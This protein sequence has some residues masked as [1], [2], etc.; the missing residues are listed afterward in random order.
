MASNTRTL[1]DE[2]GDF[3]DWIELQNTSATN[4]NL[5]NWALTDS[6]G[7]P[8]EWL[9]P[10]TNIGPGNFLIVFASGKDRRVAGAPLHTSFK[11]SAD[12]E[13]LALFR[14]D[15]TAATEFSPGFPSQ[16]PDVSYGVGMCTTNAYWRYF[17]VPTPGLTNGTSTNDLG[18]L[19]S[20]AG[21]GPLVPR[22]S[23]ALVVTA[24]VAQA[25]SPVA[26]VALHYRVMFS[27]EVTVAM[28][29][30][31][32]N[33]DAL[34]GDGIWSGTIPGSVAG[35]G[36]MIRYYVTAVDAAQNSSRWPIYANAQESQQYFGTVVRDDSIQS[37]LPVA[38]F[39][40]ENTAASDT[41]TGTPGS[42]F[43]LGEFYDNLTVAIHGQSSTG[44]PKKSHDLDFPKD[45]QFLYRTNGVREKKITF[46]S[47]YGDKARLCTSLTYAIVAQ[48]GG[49]AFFSF[50]IRIHL[51][52]SFWGIEDLVEH[53][54]EA[55]LT[56]IGRDPNGALYKMY[57]ALDS[58]SGN[59]K[60]TRE[61]EGMDDL[62]ALITSLDEARPQADRETFAYDNLDLPQTANYFATLAIA[63]EQDHGHKNYFLYH[64]NDGTG[65][66]AI[67]PWDVDLSWGR[68]WLDYAGYFTDTIF[69]NNVL[70]FYNPAQ[71]YKPN[72]RLYDLFFASTEFRQMY[73]RRLR[74]LMD[75]V[76]LPP[77]TPV[78]TTT[79][80]QFILTH[81]SLLNPPGISPTDAQLDHA[82]WGPAWGDWGLGQDPAM[83]ELIRTNY[84]P[85]RRGFLFQSAAATL[86]GD[87]IPAA[88]PTNATVLI[89]GWDYAPVSGNANEQ[90]VELHNTNAFAADV[91]GWKLGG[92]IT[93]TLRPGTVI[94]AGKSLYVAANVN[95][96]RT[97][98]VSPH[99]GQ[100]IF[101]QGPFSGFLSSQGNSALVL[102]DSR[103]ALVSQNVYAINL[104]SNAFAAGNLA[105]VRVGNGTESLSSHGNSVFI[106]QF[107]TNGA[108]IGSVAVPN[109]GTNGF[110]I[111]G[112]ASSEGGL[113]RSPDGRLLVLAGYRI[114]LTNAALLSSS[115]ANGSSTNAPRGLMA[116]DVTG[117]CGLVGVVT[118]QFSGNN[119]RGGA[120][121]GRGNYWGAGAVS[122]TYY[123]GDGAGATVQ[124]VV[125][126]TANIE[127]AGGNLY[128]STS[129][130][131]PGIWKIC[132]TP[133]TA[134]NATVVLTSATASPFAFA[135]NPGFTT[136]Y[137]AD[138]TPGSPGGVQRWDLHGNAWTM[139]YAFNGLTS[140][141]ARGLAVDFGTVPPVIYATTAE[142]SA[143]RLVALADTGAAA[144]VNT[145]ATSGVNQLYRG[146]TFT[147]D[148]GLSP[149]MFSAG[150]C[151]NGFRLA[152]T[153]LMNRCYTVEYAD[154]LMSTNWVTLTNV[155]ACGPV[156]AV[157]DTNPAIGTNRF[158]RIG[159]VGW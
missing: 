154:D 83:A 42:L 43:Y 102:K 41:E 110:I 116:V 37:L 126:N 64:D 111:S 28:N 49:A 74:T 96:F 22:A 149:Q 70:N 136:A 146:V 95:A 8:A 56:R 44:W 27:S 36:Q 13:Y 159:L 16:F 128:F 134:T 84:L 104:S 123:F 129:K 63:S 26:A 46:L 121:D 155:T 11:L 33:G 15:H 122:G 114:A 39:F 124:S 75:T 53:S 103:D 69:T 17:S 88:Q 76:L 106:D 157:I 29:D 19:L 55:W 148:A 97:R 135:F 139:S 23:D 101:V 4:V 62:S 115:L 45:H 119:I 80:E 18:P 131:T 1:T 120:T 138:D 137:V 2:N 24:R 12:G 153:T 40:I 32:T 91:S 5:F 68:N 48:C 47:N 93:F 117:T 112:S 71:Q 145:L 107:T 147:P 89:G 66:W 142:S 156:A 78:N 141:G 9:F 50:P 127:I 59:E 113:T 87:P 54:D 30:A 144:V 25:E 108:L 152:W 72:N 150:P 31:G 61:W 82:T 20:G 73:L 130:T 57:N 6:A 10:A 81:E 100:N 51:N 65:E 143:N 92:S 58:V 67:F 94:P 14:P 151:T 7:N 132:G 99:A 21:H 118:N 98:A 38:Q 3:P 79:I 158:Y 52:G 35:V 133:P 140:V 105:V 109:G 125:K 90:F 85:G 60:K 34:A 77:G 86:N